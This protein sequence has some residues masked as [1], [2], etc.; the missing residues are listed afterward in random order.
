MYKK[1]L[2]FFHET[3]K[4]KEIRQNNKVLENLLQ[5]EEC[6]CQCVLQ[7]TIFASHVYYVHTVVGQ[8]VWI[9]TF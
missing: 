6:N 4:L 3:K 5:L 7:Q 2:Y 9:F 1:Q 8:G